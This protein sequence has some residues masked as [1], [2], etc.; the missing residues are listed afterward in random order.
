MLI[1][2]RTLYREAGFVNGSP[3]LDVALRV[4]SSDALGGQTLYGKSKVFEQDPVIMNVPIPD[5]YWQLAAVPAGGWQASPTRPYIVF[6][7]SIATLAVTGLLAA[8][9]FLLLGR[10]REREKYRYLV[11]N[12]KS[13]ILRIDM[14]GNITFCNEHAEEFYGYEPGELIGK[15]LIGTLIPEKNLEGE[16]MKRYIHRLLKNP[17][18][19]PFNETMNVCKNGEVVWVAWAHES[20]NARDGSMVELLSVGTDITD[21]KLMEEALRQSERQYRLL[22]ENV[23]DV[24]WGLDADLRYTFV[25]PSDETL[26]GFKRYDVL[27][28]P[29][30]DFLTPASSRRLT[31]E[32][33]AMKGRVAD[34]RRPVSMTL[35]LEFVSAD[36]ASV[37]LENRVGLLLND[38]GEIIGV[39]G[40]GRD[41]TDRK[42]AEALREDV[43]R[44]AQHDLKTPLGAV[45]GLPG[46]I[47]R[48]GKLSQSQE[49]MLLTI[50]DAGEAMLQLIN[51]S[52]DLYKMER[53]TYVLR[54]KSVDVLGLLESIK[55]E[56][57]PVIRE[58]GIS[59]GIEAR[60]VDR[61]FVFWVTVEEDLFRSML[62]NL[63]LNALQASP[64]GGSISITLDGAEEN[65][66]SI[67]NTGEVPSEIREMFFDKYVSSKSSAGSGLGTYSARLIARTHGGDLVVDTETPGETCVSVILPQ[68][69]DF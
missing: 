38:D 47:R 9:I 3:G 39:Q 61:R 32:V 44:M 51:R 66:I 62:S 65:A 8:A 20:V 5:G 40:V 34:S 27:G 26:R 53:G 4:P 57:L 16:S 49:N 69:T 22:A 24:I 17:S 12:A 54:K 60:G 46:E 42:L 11:Q 19:H 13:I 41:I 45:V 43:E 7:G 23:T 48:L 58:K 52:L 25:S 31:S 6:G 55:A 30:E 63:I 2:A 67:C 36:G 18:A 59:V 28:R 14:A 15:P 10:L 29:I 68:E 56:L 64:E 37:W 35:D 21:R 50:E 1:D 33:E